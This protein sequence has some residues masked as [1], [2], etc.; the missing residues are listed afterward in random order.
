M[1]L[2]Q[3]AGKAW[4]QGREKSDSEFRLV[5]KKLLDSP[6]VIAGRNFSLSVTG[7][8]FDDLLC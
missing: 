1:Y 8:N 5:K 3:P 4:F 6:M 7:D 2:N